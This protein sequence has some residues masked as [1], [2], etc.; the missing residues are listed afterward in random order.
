[1][2]A[3]ALDAAAG[4]FCEAL[5]FSGQVGLAPARAGKFASPVPLAPVTLEGRGV[6]LEP[7]GRQ[8]RD[9]LLAAAADGQLWELKVTVVPSAATI[10]AYLAEARTAAEAGREL[11]FAIRDRATDRIVG[12]TRY[13]MIELAH[14]RLEIGSTFLA[15]SAQRTA[16]NTEAKL[17]LLTHAFE[18][19]GCQ[20]VELLTDV[21]NTRS[22]AAI[23]RLG[24]VAEGIFRKHLIMPDGRQRDSVIYS[25]LAGE[26]PAVKT[27]LVGRLAPRP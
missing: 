13:R 27:G 24:A 3:C 6:R 17:L 12:S 1:M 19:L 15:A 25:I 8:H 10:D 23:L 16:I 22:R 20:R 2:S 11:P 7:L 21:L 9:A 4:R 26:W 18:V 14:R 5:K